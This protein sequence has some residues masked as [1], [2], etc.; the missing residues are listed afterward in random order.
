MSKSAGKGWQTNKP[1]LD[2]ASK[3]KGI[4]EKNSEKKLLCIYDESMIIFIYYY[5]YNNYI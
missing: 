5:I 2:R 3:G 1:G 4:K